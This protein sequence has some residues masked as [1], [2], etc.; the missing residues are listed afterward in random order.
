MERLSPQAQAIISRY[1][2][3]PDSNRGSSGGTTTTGA[4]SSCPSDEA[5]DA[6]ISCPSNEIDGDGGWPPV[7][8]HACC[9]NQAASASACASTSVAVPPSPNLAAVLSR[10]LP[11]RIPYEADYRALQV[12][13]EYASW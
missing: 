8:I 12:E 11:W 13:S 9:D 5:A 4:G 3:S 2:S 10:A 1:T 7:P 6:G